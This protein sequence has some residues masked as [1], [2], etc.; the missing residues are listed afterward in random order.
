MQLKIKNSSATKLIAFQIDKQRKKGNFTQ[1]KTNEA[2]WKSYICTE[3]STCTCLELQNMQLNTD[4]QLM[5][6]SL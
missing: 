5:T 6:W 4:V 3:K 1:Q 2:E